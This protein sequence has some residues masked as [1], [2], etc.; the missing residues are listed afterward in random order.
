MAR[1]GLPA[2][3]TTRLPALPGPDHYLGILCSPPHPAARTT[4]LPALPGPDHYLGI[5]PHHPVARTITF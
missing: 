3:R 5:F 2:A 1:A 4:R